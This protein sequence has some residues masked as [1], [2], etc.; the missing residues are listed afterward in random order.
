ML[1]LPL[2]VNDIESLFQLKRFYE[3]IT[4]L[5]SASDS[6]YDKKNLSSGEETKLL[7]RRVLGAPL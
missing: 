1:G 6:A 4:L 2:R 7:Y 5:N 3:A